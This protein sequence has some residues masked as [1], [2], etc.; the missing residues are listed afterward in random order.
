MAH[1]WQIPILP[2]LERHAIAES[3]TCAPMVALEQGG[4]GAWV[5]IQSI[6]S[7]ARMWSAGIQAAHAVQIALALILAA[8]LAWL[9]QSDAAFD[10]KASAPATANLSR[11]R[12]LNLPA[13]PA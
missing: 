3:T 9:W 6:F 12:D 7:A 13:M 1:F 5:K 2:L 11:K 8:S 10:L 4:T